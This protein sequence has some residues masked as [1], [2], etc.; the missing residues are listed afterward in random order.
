VKG[1]V[2]LLKYANY[3]SA[4]EARTVDTDKLWVQVQYSY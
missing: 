3:D 4:D 2:G 1:L